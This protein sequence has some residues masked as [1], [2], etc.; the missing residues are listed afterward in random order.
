MR[1]VIAGC[2]RVGSDL[3][4]TFADR[5][6]DVSVIGGDEAE[7]DRLG[8]TFNGTT[9]VGLAH[10]VAVQQ[11][12]GME[13]ADAFI[14]VTPSDN[15]NLMAVQVAKK[16]FA[17]PRAVARLDDPARADS[18]RALDI[19]F[20]AASTLV[21][22][23]IYEEIVDEEFQ[24]H[25]SFS[26]GDVEVVEMKISAAADTSTVSELEID[27]EVRVA[28]VRRGSH[29]YVPTSDFQLRTGDL[30]VA[31]ARFKSR[32]KLRRFSEE[33]RE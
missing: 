17:V 7:F 26:G 23:V 25:V 33:G 30:V 1:I 16:V 5:D 9:H 22:R 6:H 4:L 32:P 2:G 29:T 11:G 27:G 3:G 19:Q 21:A 24:Y 13:H 28:A 8:S 15:G 18:Y 20:V 31:A 14:A 12:A 10:D